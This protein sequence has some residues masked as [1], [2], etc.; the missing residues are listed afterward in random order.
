MSSGLVKTIVS[1]GQTGADRA[2]LDLAI[3]N[4]IPYGG[5]CP[6]GGWA[7]DYPE[8]PGLLTKY[9][10]LRETPNAD[11]AQRTEW[12]VRD[13]SLTLILL[14]N[15]ELER[16]KGT[17]LTIAVAKSLGRPCLVIKMNSDRAIDHARDWLRQKLGE[18]VLNVAGPR[19]SESPTL[20]LHAGA[21]LKRALSV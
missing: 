21:F 6:K 15:G 18:G 7:E 12:N 8:P 10:N 3:A 13:S 9:P 5:W 16:S 19:E 20:Y 2:A 14:N 11:P 4:G 1:G 17:Q